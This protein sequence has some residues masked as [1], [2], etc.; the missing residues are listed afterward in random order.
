MIKFAEKYCGG[1]H[2]CGVDEYL[3]RGM[4]NLY[5]GSRACAKLDN[6]VGEHF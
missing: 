4:S 2:E 1:L 5:N 6:R 3:I